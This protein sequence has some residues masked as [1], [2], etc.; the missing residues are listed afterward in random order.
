[1]AAVVNMRKDH[2]HDG[3]R[4]WRGIKRDQWEGGHRVPM[5]AKWPALT[6]GGSVSEQTTCLTDIMATAAAI[7]GFELPDNAAEDSFDLLPVLLGK[8][9]GK[10]V[11]PFTLHQTWGPKYAIRAGQWKYIDH[12]G[13][14]GN[15]YR[16]WPGLDAYILPDTAPDAP[17]QLYDLAND[18]GETTNLYF[19]HP[20]RVKEMKALLDASIASG[21]SAPLRKERG[22]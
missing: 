8:D 6:S 15:D 14:G 22:L 16:R 18:P 11:R 19:Q 7:T 4:P 20:A 21:R 17:G 9:G 1:V 2:G 13:S 5:I 12:Q 10:P 3:A